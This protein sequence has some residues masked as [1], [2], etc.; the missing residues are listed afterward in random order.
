MKKIYKIVAVVAIVAAAG[1]ITYNAQSDKMQ[2][3]TLAID[4]VEA[5][6]NGEVSFDYLCGGAGNCWDDYYDTHFD[7]HRIW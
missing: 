4:N 5:L 7:G 1:F 2:L 3:S 6:A